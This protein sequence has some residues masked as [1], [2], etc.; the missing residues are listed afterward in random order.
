MMSFFNKSELSRNLIP[1]HVNLF[2]LSTGNYAEM[3]SILKSVQGNNFTQ[4]GLD[5]CTL[6]DELKVRADRS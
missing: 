3:Y 5:T 4:L 1:A 6:D 2:Q